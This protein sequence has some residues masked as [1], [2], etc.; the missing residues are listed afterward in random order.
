MLTAVDEPRLKSYVNVI[1]FSSKGARPDENKMGAGDLDGDIYWINWRKEFIDA[2]ME[3]PA[4]D[5]DNLHSS[6]IYEYFS[7]LSSNKENVLDVKR[8][9]CIQNFIKFLK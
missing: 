8:E 4:E 6:S 2:Y 9:H 3:A 7:R 1:V 5:R